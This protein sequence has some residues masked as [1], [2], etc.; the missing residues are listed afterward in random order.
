MRLRNNALS[1]VFY[2]LSP[3]WVILFSAFSFDCYAD[4]A[5]KQV[6]PDI[7]QDEF[8][9]D[10]LEDAFAFLSEGVELPVQ[11]KLK[12][13]GYDADN[14]EPNG[15][16][17][18]KASKDGVIYIS[19]FNF[20]KQYR[21][22]LSSE[23]LS[24][25]SAR[26]VGL[27][28]DGMAEIGHGTELSLDIS[29]MMI[30][31]NIAD[32]DLG[33]ESTQAVA[34]SASEQNALSM[35]TNYNVNA[36][37]SGTSLNGLSDYNFST[38]FNN[39]LSYEE[40]HLRF[41]N[42]AALSSDNEV[43]Q[44]LDNLI[45]ARDA[46]G[47]RAE[48]G[49][50]TSAPQRVGTISNFSIDRLYYASVTNA[51][52]S[53]LDQNYSVSLIPLIISMPSAGE[54]RVYKDDRL[55]YITTLNIGRHELDTKSFPSG[56]YE[57]KIDTVIAGSV[58]DTKKYRVNKPANGRSGQQLVW[59]LWAG[60]AKHENLDHHGED[61]DEYVSSYSESTKEHSAVGG[62]NL[63]SSIGE[64]T[65]DANLYR[66]PASWVA[67]IG[68]GWQALEWLSLEGQW[69]KSAKG[70]DRAFYQVYI[71]PEWGPSLTITSERGQY[72]EDEYHETNSYGVDQAQL[73]IP[74]PE[75]IPGGAL[76]LGYNINREYDE[77]S[78]NVDYSQTLLDSD[79]LSLSLDTGVDRTLGEEAETN[80]YVNLNASIAIGGS[81]DVGISEQNGIKTASLSAGMGLD[82]FFNYV[83]ID[84]QGELVGDKIESPS[85]SLRANY[86]NSYISGNTSIGI[87]ESNVNMSNSSSGLLAFN[88]DGIAPGKGSGESGFMVVM[89]KNIEEEELELLVDDAATPLHAGANFVSA[90]PYREHNVNIQVSDNAQSSYDVLTEDKSYTLYPGNVSTIKPVVKQMVTVFGRLLD[91]SGAAIANASIKNHIGET[92]TDEDGGFSIDVD[93]SIPE[94]EVDSTQ[95]GTFK[96]AM[97]IPATSGGVVRL[98]D[99]VWSPRH[100]DVYIINPLF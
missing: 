66:S 13:S 32:L 54:V 3:L 19:E 82:G 62:V 68:S 15:V 50:D 23:L 81:V 92:V 48:L 29:E 41:S 9:S 34:K 61:S 7:K 20:D 28:D 91:E 67:E 21:S 93:A 58:R 79:L 63:S 45:L 90:S 88:R 57:V 72:D 64:V 99:L 4:V 46:N 18:V 74:L 73:S 98:K 51:A 77:R 55:I 14:Y 56:V 1:Y 69:M 53:L 30:I 49:M 87:S 17:L 33:G 97:D 37:S 78:W 52:D 85:T 38:S 24:A 76:S 25:L 86:E 83:S 94:V 65:W 6:Q 95:T 100:T 36:Y 35:L 60:E 31:M 22:T 80:Y 8:K 11:F 89:P 10:I 40:N 96:V 43:T 47:L 2:S 39:L 59:Q 71:S 12:Q 84:A 44:E 70:G 26:P 16:A 42:F 5:T 27:N 75:E